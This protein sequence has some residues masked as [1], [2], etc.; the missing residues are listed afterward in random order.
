MKKIVLA[1]GSPRRKELLK[2]MGFQIDVKTSNKEEKI[3]TQK[4]DKAV[5][6]LARMKAADIMG[7]FQ[8]PC[9]VIG[10]DTIVV[11]DGYEILGKPKDKNHAFEMIK[12]LQGTDHKVYTGVAILEKNMDGRVEEH[13]FSEKTKV[14]VV[15]MSKNE[16]E[17]YLQTEVE[18]ET[19]G[20]K[21]DT[22]YEW[23]DKAGGYGIQGIFSKYISGIEGDY[24]NVVGLPV[25]RLYHE[26][27]KIAGN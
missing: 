22:I 24:Y 23:K 9:I 14:T 17:K 16:I 25:C 2:L 11:A 26:L 18:S 7:Q 20:E 5:Q 10:A 1:S 6:E 4:P 15:P 21:K 19:E 8:E 3:T 27:R 13:I 12:K